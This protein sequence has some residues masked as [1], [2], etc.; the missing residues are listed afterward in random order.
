MYSTTNLNVIIS[1]IKRELGITPLNKS[2]V[3]ETIS[4]SCGVQ[5]NSHLVKQGDIFI[6]LQGT[7]VDGGL[8]LHS[9]FNNG[10]VL[11]IIN[12]NAFTCIKNKIS[13]HNILVYPSEYIPHICGVLEIYFKPGIEQ[14]N[15]V[16]VTGTN[17]KTTTTHIIHHILNTCGIKTGLIGTINARIGSKEYKTSHTTLPQVEYYE[18]LGQARM[19]ECSAVTM[20]VSSH[21]LSQGRVAGV[22]FQT[23]VFT[24]LTRDHLDYHGTMENYFAVK[25]KIISK[26]YLAND[27]V[28]VIN[29]DDEYGQKLYHQAKKNGT[30]CITFSRDPNNYLITDETILATNIS[31]NIRNITATVNYIGDEVEV[32]IPLVGS[33][34]LSNTLAAIA[35]GLR[36][37][38]SLDQI[39]NALGSLCSING[40]M[41]PVPCPKKDVVILIDYAHTPDALE[42]V[43][44]SVKPLTK[45]KLWCVFGC[46]GDRDKGK[47]PMMG[48]IAASYADAIVVTSDNPRHEHPADIIEDIIVGISNGIEIHKINS[49]KEAI[50][51]AIK[52][53][54]DNDAIIIAG[55]GHENF[56]IF[57]TEKEPFID[58]EVASHAAQSI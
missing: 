14:L 47:R 46:G 54:N 42:N 48:S 20:E 8:F 4:L 44:K 41:M 26:E 7:R 12:N 50:E 37:E 22:K 5:T 1:L 58:Y 18:M 31:Y 15:L 35:V 17:G 34:N 21:S 10:A 57:G 28:A 52:H 24:N 19:E 36:N 6:G 39:S 11:A 45:G 13:L 56:Q 40:R 27:G 29:I 33:Y 38:L 16:G 3:S 2:V 25:S 23:S 9:A 32:S 43:L 51:Y 30:T 55:K 53:A 49:R